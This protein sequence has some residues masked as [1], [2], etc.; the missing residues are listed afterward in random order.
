VIIKHDNS[1]TVSNG[2]QP[3]VTTARQHSV[4]FIH[5]TRQCIPPPRHVFPVPRCGSGS[6]SGSVIR[7]ATNLTIASLAHFHFFPENYMQIRSE[8]FAQSW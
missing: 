2:Q 6:V 5:P 3:L 4:K 1:I 7:I 8:V